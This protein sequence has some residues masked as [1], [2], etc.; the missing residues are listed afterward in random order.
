MLGV[1]VSIVSLCWRDSMLRGSDWNDRSRGLAAL[2]K[3]D[4]FS[5]VRAV[6]TTDEARAEDKQL[7]NGVIKDVQDKVAE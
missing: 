1:A 7:P 6:G 3:N 4:G 2:P 5:L